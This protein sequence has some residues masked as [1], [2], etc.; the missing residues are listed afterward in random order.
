MK[1]LSVLIITRDRGDSIIPWYVKIV[2]VEPPSAGAWGFQVAGLIPLGYIMTPIDVI[3]DS[4]VFPGQLD[5]LI[6][7]RV[8]YIVLRKNIAQDVLNENGES[9][10]LFLTD[11]KKQRFKFAFIISAIWIAFGTFLTLYIVKKMRI[12][13]FF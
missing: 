8:S 11:G 6:I 4:L 5:E 7:I 13:D 2:V 1:E 12:Y 10:R 3:P 9:A